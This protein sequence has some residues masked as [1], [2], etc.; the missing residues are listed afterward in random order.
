MAITPAMI[1]RH[2]T[3]EALAGDQITLS[4]EAVPGIGWP[5][6]TIDHING[7]KE[8]NRIVNLRDGVVVDITRELSAYASHTQIF[9]PQS[10]TD[11]NGVPL[12]AVEGKTTEAIDALKNLLA[13]TSKRSY[14][15]EIGRAHV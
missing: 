11:A 2:R 5:A 4:H 9:N 6:M 14:S 15:Q 12:D 3:I 10:E 1:F 13:T 8:D 7:V